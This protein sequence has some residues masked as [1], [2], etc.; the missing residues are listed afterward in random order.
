MGPIKAVALGYARLLN[1]TGRARRAEYW[2]F[3]AWQFL[4]AAV[5]MGWV[6]FE[7]ASRARVDPAFAALMQNPQQM[8]AYVNS[9]YAGNELPLTIAYFVLFVIPNLSLTIRRL[10]DT[11]RSGWLIFMPALVAIASVFGGF[12]LMG[13]A[14]ASSS[15]GGMAL[16]TLAMS[17][18]SLVASIWFT[19]WLCLPG[20]NGPN[21]F[22]PDSVK[23]RKAK[24]PSHPA[25]AAQLDGAALD[26]SEVARKAA[27]HDYYQRRVLPSIQKA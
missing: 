3:F 20:T 10:H 7:L 19:V 24:A 1:F 4:L 14:A 18:P 5:A 25:F 9:L 26:R 12:F 21:R 17:V 11:D 6:A 2:W 15:G 13:A 22:G 27:A 23:N 16:A 8:E